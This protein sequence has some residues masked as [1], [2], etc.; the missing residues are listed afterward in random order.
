MRPRRPP[1]SGQAG[2]TLVEFA[3][4][5]VIFLTLLLGILDFSRMLWTWAAAN[6]ATRW[7]ARVAVICSKNAPAVLASM[8]KF[9]PQLQAAN[10][11]VDWYTQ[12][13]LNNTCDTSNCRAVNVRI[14]G[15]QHQWISPIGWTA[16]Q[17][18][19]MPDFATYLPTESM[20]LD[21]QSPSVCS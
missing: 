17:L 1:S 4:G 13:G 12:D 9:V 6:E 11:Q 3:L 14:V 2:A 21:P 10:L 18:I 8:R 20:G 15:L 7:G 5:L 16:G 19:P